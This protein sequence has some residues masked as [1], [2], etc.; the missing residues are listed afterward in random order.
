MLTPHWF[1]RSAALAALALAAGWTG[2]VVAQPALPPSLPA[3]HMTIWRFMG[4][5]QGINMIRDATVNTRG[6]FPGLERKPPLK[7]IGDPA[8]L[9]ADN[10]A[11]KKA[12]EIKIQE[13]LKKQKIKAIKY[14]ATIGCGCYKGVAE[15]LIAALDDCTEEVRYEAAKALS[16][17]SSNKC[18]HCGSNS[19]CGKEV[20]E[21]LTELGYERDEAGCWKES[22]ER[23]REMAREAI[24][25]C[26]R[27]AGPGDFIEV[28]DE[29]QGGETIIVPVDPGKVD[30][31]QPTP[32][33][34]PPVDPP[35]APV[36]P[37]EAQAPVIKSRQASVEM[38][39]SPIVAAPAMPQPEVYEAEIDPQ[40]E[41]AV[42]EIPAPVES[43][44]QVRLL[45][46]PLRRMAG[47]PELHSAGEQVQ[48][49][50]APVAQHRPEQHVQRSPQLVAPAQV[51]E[52][53][54]VPSEVAQ[55]VVEP[56]AEKPYS[57]AI[58]VQG[59]VRYIDLEQSRACI[60]LPEHCDA[61]IGDTLRVYRSFGGKP[62]MI[63]Q[64]RVLG[65][66]AQGEAV[67]EPVGGTPIQ[68]IALGDICKLRMKVDAASVG[69]AI[70]EPEHLLP[71]PVA[72]LRPREAQPVVHG[73]AKTVAP[74][75][76]TMSESVASKPAARKPAPAVASSPVG[77][78]PMVSATPRS[79]SQRPTITGPVVRSTTPVVAAEKPSADAAPVASQK[80]PSK[81]LFS[82]MFN[83]RDPSEIR[84]TS[85]QR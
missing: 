34:M 12:A 8:N 59:S 77:A 46:A 75:A 42:A 84:Q 38:G 79:A 27:P 73:A 7:R 20:L 23:V 72:G 62:E 18:Q 1:R 22:S 81:G 54:P 15:A 29:T 30:P 43:K 19:C 56:A 25:G 13:D 64:M 33:P 74:P 45:P 78:K 69:V 32:P 67:V 71:G 61:Q 51:A 10:E 2:D 85:G 39:P 66:N 40:P 68:K 55:V 37:T 28:I 16:E 9:F 17:V 31:N 50:P 24:R 53:G 82:E 58:E 3:P 11:I 76:P 63:G 49:K 14:L 26:T 70:G 52:V 4:I 47:L 65:R 41:E 36:P 60:G 48:A 44:G 57:V 80:A 6:N 35:P 5:P 21:K 83:V